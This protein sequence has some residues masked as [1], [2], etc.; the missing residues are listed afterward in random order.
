MSARGRDGARRLPRAACAF[1]LALAAACATLPARADPS[2]P[3][4][5]SASD[6]DYSAG[7][8]AVVQ[9]RWAEAISALQKA[10]VRFP[11]DADLQNDL[12]YAYRNLGQF[13]PA[14]RHYKRALALDPRHRGA[15]EYIGEAYLLVDDLPGAERHL[16]ALGE[17]CLLP[18]EQQD[19]LRKAVA[20]YKA[21]KGAR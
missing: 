19:D 12:G 10:A 9:R 15:H 1:A 4:E 18:C 13:E 20:A 16:A 17:I 14:F 7:R 5:A 2:D 21:R 11:D 8:A 3:N 6:A